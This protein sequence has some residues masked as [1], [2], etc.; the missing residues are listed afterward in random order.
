MRLCFSKEHYG[1][2]MYEVPDSFT[3]SCEQWIAMEKKKNQQHHEDLDDFPI[4]WR[5]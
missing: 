5:V 3:G 4:W 2:V 1:E